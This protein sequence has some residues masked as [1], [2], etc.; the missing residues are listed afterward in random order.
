MGLV[1]DGRAKDL[2]II[3]LL[4]SSLS[5]RREEPQKNRYDG[6]YIHIFKG[7]T[8]LKEAPNNTDCSLKMLNTFS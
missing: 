8:K 2:V 5:R 7:D 3:P 6:L 1:W 4:Q